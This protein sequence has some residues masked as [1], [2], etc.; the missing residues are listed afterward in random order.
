MKA[1]MHGHALAECGYLFRKPGE[2][3]AACRISSEYAFPTPL[4]RFGSVNARLSVW[5][6][7]R[8]RAANS[9]SVVC[10]ISRPPGSSCRRASSPSINCSDARRLVPA[11]VTVSVPLPNSS[12]ASAAR[13]DRG[14][15]CSNQWSRPAIMRCKTSQRSPSSPIARRLPIRLT[16]TTRRPSALAIGGSA[17]RRKNGDTISRRSRR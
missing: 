4:N 3:L 12:R 13:F 1:A 11:S 17:V 15:S 7:L 5:F 8:S 14:A 9:S 10:S 2:S 16:C 6:S